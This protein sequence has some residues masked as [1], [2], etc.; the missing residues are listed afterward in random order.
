MDDI[1]LPVLR[2]R[3]DVYFVVG[4]GFAGKHEPPQS[5]SFVYTFATIRGRHDVNVGDLWK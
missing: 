5:A 2:P 4:L 3:E 1:I